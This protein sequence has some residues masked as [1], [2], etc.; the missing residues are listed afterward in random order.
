MRYQ[1]PHT[2]TTNIE[3]LLQGY[4]SKSIIDSYK[5]LEPRKSKWPTFDPMILFFIS[6]TLGFGSIAFCKIQEWDAESKW[7]KEQLNRVEKDMPRLQAQIQDLQ[8]R[9]Q[10]L[11]YQEAIREKQMEEIMDRVLRTNLLINQH[12]LE[13]LQANKD[14]TQ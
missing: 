6:I 1:R 10:D 13:T 7:Q 4:E 14:T 11:R 9:L 3:S 12:R 8:P 5:A 2:R